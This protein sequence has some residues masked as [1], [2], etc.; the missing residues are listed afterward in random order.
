MN[1]L[2]QESP[3]SLNINIRKSFIKNKD[4]YSVSLS[5]SIIENS[6][7]IDEASEGQKM[8]LEKLEIENSS[9]SD[10]LEQLKVELQEGSG[11]SSQARNSIRKCKT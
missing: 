3:F 7:K 6:N 4:G 1:F 11:C 8:K 5:V 9:L 2:I 10:S